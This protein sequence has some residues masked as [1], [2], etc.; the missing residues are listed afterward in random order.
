MTIRTSVFSPKGVSRDM[1]RSK[2]SPDYLFDAY[3]IRFTARGNNKTLLS[4][5]NEKGNSKIEISGDSIKGIYVGHCVINQWLVLFTTYAGTDYIYRINFDDNTGKLLY[6]GN[7]NFSAENNPIETLGV[8]EKEDVIKVYWID[9]RN[10]PRMINIMGDYSTKTNNPFDFVQQ[11]KGEETVTIKKHLD[12]NGTFQ[13][14]TIQYAFTYLNLYGQETDMFYLS[15]LNYIAFKDRGASPETSVNCQFKINITKLDSN[16]EYVRIYSIH[17]TSKNG[18]PSIKRIIDLPNTSDIT[19]V[20]T[21]TTGEIVDTTYLLYAGGEDITASAMSSKD[22]TLFLG[23]IVLNQRQINSDV[24]SLIKTQVAPTLAFSTKKSDYAV[25]STSVYSYQNTLATDANITFK[26]GETYRFGLVFQYKTG[27][28]SEVCYLDDK[29]NP[30]YPSYKDT[31]INLSKC[32]CTLPASLAQTM[33]NNGYIK[34]MPVCVYPDINNRSVIAQGVLNPT[35][36]DIKKRYSNEPFSYA[37]PFFRPIKPDAVKSTDNTYGNISYNEFRHNTEIPG[38]NTKKWNSEFYFNGTNATLYT[39]SNVQPTGTDGL[40]MFVDCS[41]CTLNSPEIEFDTDIQ[42]MDL[43]NCKL[44]I[45]GYIPIEDTISDID[46][47]TQTSPYYTDAKGF[48]KLDYTSTGIGGFN[49]LIASPVYTDVWVSNREQTQSDLSKKESFKFIICPWQKSGSI[50]NFGSPDKTILTKPCDLKYNKMSLLRFSRQTKYLAQSKI[51][52]TGDISD[53]KI[54]NFDT[55]GMVKLSEPK[56]TGAGDLVYYGNVNEVLLSKSKYDTMA[57]LLGK[58]AAYTACNN[59][60]AVLTTD[61]YSTQP[62]SMKYKS[63]VHAVF[64]FDNNGSTQVILPTVDNTGTKINSSDYSGPAPFWYNRN[65]SYSGYNSVYVDVYDTTGTLPDAKGYLEAIQYVN[66]TYTLW[67][68]DTTVNNQTETS[69]WV[70]DTFTNRTIYAV[71]DQRNGMPGSG[72]V[73]KTFVYNNSVLSETDISTYTV[74]QPSIDGTDIFADNRGFLWLGE[75]YVDNITSRFGGTS[76]MALSNNR[77]ERCGDSMTLVNADMNIIYDKGDTYYQRY[78]CLKTYPYTL[79]DENSVVDILSFMCETHINIDGRY[80]RNRGQT[81]NLVMTPVNFNLMNDAYTQHDNYKLFNYL[82]PYYSKVSN[83]PS[84]ITMTEEKQNGAKHDVWTNI[85]MAVT[86]DMDGDKGEITSI[87]RFNNELFC[88]Q[89]TGLSNIL[90][91]SRVQIPAS[92]NTPIQITNGLKLQGKIYLSDKVGCINKWSI[93]ETPDGLYFIDNIT[94]SLYRFDGKLSSLSDSLGM[95]TWV[96]SVNY[97]KPWK[98]SLIDDN[99]FNFRGFYDKNNNDIYWVNNSC[100][101]AFSELLGQFTGFYSY[102][103]IPAMF[104][105]ND[106]FYAYY[107]GSDYNYS[108][109]DG[110]NTIWKMWSGDYNYFFGKGRPYWVTYTDNSMPLY[111]KIFDNLNFRLEAYSSDTSDKDTTESVNSYIPDKCFDLLEVHNEYQ[112][113]ALVLQTSRNSGISLSPTLRKRFKVWRTVFPRSMENGRDRI[114][115]TWCNV[116]LSYGLNPPYPEGID[117]YRIELHD[118]MINYF[119]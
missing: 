55:A 34:V 43:R 26:G 73:I 11:L 107:P 93:V 110:A 57:S 14:G 100:C 61:Q 49:H 94:N 7:M 99:M 76:E 68:S 16:F 75:F 63:T 10:Q 38:L 20:D 45:V 113:G 118:M 71:V 95:R 25:D 112:D 66:G 67:R 35:M 119:L 98:P 4:I 23:N 1:T 19:Y 24:K 52:K 81:N 3:N 17:R 64:A 46:V 72:A 12:S 108:S 77:W 47:Q 116:K 114:R 5:T 8:Y 85:T 102:E 41:I 109:G 103:K 89:R 39:G 21:G 51:W 70:A 37:S 44:R 53:I 90:F 84:T 40:S 56:N 86:L 87:N 65:T 9:G 60:T 27:K 18:T 101:I 50:N 2:F 83:F 22:N 15:D 79:E 29:E 31:E 78:D 69:T 74:N 97:L 115:N 96:S 42:N 6:S 91:N 106:D 62:I 33:I 13:E 80:D 30:L 88:F 28:W 32:S 117:K 36:F 92:D 54:Y 58:P 59:D 111:D 104:N 48:S 105:I 82:E